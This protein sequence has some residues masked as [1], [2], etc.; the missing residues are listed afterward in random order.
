MNAQTLIELADAKAKARLEV[1]RRLGEFSDDALGDYLEWRA[2][3]ARE[4]DALRLAVARRREKVLR[5][6]L[7]GDDAPVMRIEADEWVIIDWLVDNVDLPLLG[8]AMRI[9]EEAGNE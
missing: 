2:S 5:A 6:K 8:Y 7:D 9:M 3:I 1:V 4:N